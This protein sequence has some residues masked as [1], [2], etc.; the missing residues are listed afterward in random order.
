[1]FGSNAWVEIRDESRFESRSLKG[2]PEVID[3][4]PIDKERAELEAFAT[5]ITGDLAYPVP[6]AD[7]IHGIAVFEAINRSAESKVTVSVG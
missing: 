3:F 4:P 6:L 2:N 5:A 1:M 7:A